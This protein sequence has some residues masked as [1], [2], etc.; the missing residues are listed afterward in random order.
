MFIS[1]ALQKWNT[2]KGKGNYVYN[3]NIFDIKS[4]YKSIGIGLLLK[5]LGIIL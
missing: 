2:F 1:I 3:G 5:L 4:L